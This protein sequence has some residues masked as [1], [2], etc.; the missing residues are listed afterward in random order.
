MVT[1]EADRVHECVALHRGLFPLVQQGVS[2]N[3]IRVN[4]ATKICTRS[5]C[6]N[7]VVL[8][9]NLENGSKRTLIA[10]ASAKEGDVR[11][12]TSTRVNVNWQLRCFVSQ[13]TKTAQEWEFP[14]VYSNTLI[15]FVGRNTS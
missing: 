5:K 13:R 1:K 3:G 11:S 9:D 15:T 2:G 10:N 6:R 12:V 4:R 7:C 14:E 8:K